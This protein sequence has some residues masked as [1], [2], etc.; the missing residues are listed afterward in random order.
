[1]GHCPFLSKSM[2]GVHSRGAMPSWSHVATIAEAWFLRSF[3]LTFLLHLLDE[4][5]SY[6]SLRIY[7]AAI[8]VHHPPQDSPSIFSH[9]LMKRFLRGLARSCPVLHRPTPSWDLPLVLRGLVSKPFEPMATAALHLVTWK[10]AFLLAI[11]SARRVGE[12]RAQCID[13]PYLTF[14][15]EGVTIFPDFFPFKS[16]F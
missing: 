15:E 16:C 6:S 5:L 8:S 2:S 14:H 1:M 7:L 12:L 4:G 11:T 3:N 10:T 9:P 13:S